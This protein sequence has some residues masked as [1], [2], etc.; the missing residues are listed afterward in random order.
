[1]L[2]FFSGHGVKDDLRDL[3]FAATNTEKQRDRLV[4]STATSA[5]FLHDCIRVCK[6]KYQVLILDCCFSGAFGDLVG[7]DDGEIP[8]KEQLGAEGRVVLASTS[9]V[10]Y[11]F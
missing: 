6:A 1:M 3:Y 8:L 2:L 11:S 7:K 10:D 4:R 9:A 5:R